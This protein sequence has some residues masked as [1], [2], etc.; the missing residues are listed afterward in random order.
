MGCFESKVSNDELLVAPT[1]NKCMDQTNT[2]DMIEMSSV[3]MHNTKLKTLMT[4]LSGNM[5]TLDTVSK[6]PFNET[7][8]ARITSVYDGD[9]V[10]LA[11]IH[12]TTIFKYKLR[13]A[14]VDT[15]ELRG[16]YS[17]VYKNFGFKAKCY[18][19]SL[20]FKNVKP[21][22]VSL[23]EVEFHCYDKFGQRLVGD[24]KFEDGEYLSQKLIANKYAMPY[25]GGKKMTEN[26]WLIHITDIS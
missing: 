9:T 3:C 10:W 25:D 5:D 7:Y 14:N 16:D 21:S 12:D 26:D 4:T 24:I 20:L 18:V 17:T 19:E 22:K 11:F 2:I 1:I 13:I 6:F 15:P 23:F 8:Q